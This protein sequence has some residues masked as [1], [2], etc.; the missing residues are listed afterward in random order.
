MYDLDN[1]YNACADIRIQMLGSDGDAF[2][3]SNETSG[4][5]AHVYREDGR[6]KTR[7][8]EK[9]GKRYWYTTPR[10]SVEEA[11][12]HAVLTALGRTANRPRTRNESRLDALAPRG[13]MDA[14]AA[15][16]AV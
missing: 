5:H 13:R 1:R 15:A 3:V 12:G 7:I 16:A 8:F 10:A 6:W 14:A 2:A 9:A 4:F 11:I